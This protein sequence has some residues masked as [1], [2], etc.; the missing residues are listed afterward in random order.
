MLCMQVQFNNCS[1]NFVGSIFRIEF[2]CSIYSRGPKISQDLIRRKILQADVMQEHFCSNLY[3]L[4][5][6][7]G[8]VI[9][10]KES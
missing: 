5:T 6:Q 10:D 4:S 1:L 8:V 3:C 9:F 2:R 7:G